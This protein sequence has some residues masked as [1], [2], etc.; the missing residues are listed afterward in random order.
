MCGLTRTMCSRSLSSWVK[1]D[2]A[3]SAAGDKRLS[4]VS[5]TPL[6]TRL[7]LSSDSTPAA[8]FSQ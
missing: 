6:G 4:V 8:L 2:V 5:C 1:F 7:T 3:V